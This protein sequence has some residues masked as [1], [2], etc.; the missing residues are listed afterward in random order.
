[1]LWGLVP[2]LFFT[3]ARQVLLTY[4]LPGLPGLAIATAV[5]LD[6]WMQSDDAHELHW[7]LRWHVAALGIAAVAAAVVAMA[8]HGGRFGL[9]P[10]LVLA[11]GVLSMLGIALLT[12]LARGAARRQ[13]IAALVVVLGLSAAVALAAAMFLYRSWIDDSNSAKAIVAEV[14]RDPAMRERTIAAPIGESIFSASYYVEVVY[15]GRFDHYAVP[16]KKEKGKEREADDETARDLL[17][18]PADEILLLKRSDWERLKSRLDGRLAPLAETVHWVA[19]RR[20]VTGAVIPGE[21]AF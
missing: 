9:A 11:V 13:N 19:C 15:G 12:M 18:R 2:P 14:Y 4:V 3:A 20:K 21:K 1:M 7:L 16:V 5:G 6:A 10:T 17:A 8:C